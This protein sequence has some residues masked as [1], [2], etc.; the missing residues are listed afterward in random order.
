MFSTDHFNMMKVVGKTD[1]KK[2]DA[3]YRIDLKRNSHTNS[4]IAY[5]NLLL[6]LTWLD[7]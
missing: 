6:M 7:D 5:G 2:W 4:S 1:E 3:I